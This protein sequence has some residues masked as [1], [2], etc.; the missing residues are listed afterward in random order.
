MRLHVM[1][2]ILLYSLNLFS[3]DDSFTQQPPRIKQFRNYKRHSSFKPY[4]RYTPEALM[5]KAC[6]ESDNDSNGTGSQATTPATSPQ[7]QLLPVD[8][9][10]GSDLLAQSDLL[11]RRKS[12]DS[13]STPNPLSLL[14]TGSMDELTGGSPL[15]TPK[16]S[17]PFHQSLTEHGTTPPTD[18]G[19]T[20]LGFKRCLTRNQIFALLTRM[21]A[22][23]PTTP[24]K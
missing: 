11:A 10:S 17:N 4:E 18:H 7:P 1:A 2:G 14:P 12:F 16:G 20:P 6:E 9:S 3:N 13:I 8:V 21:K 22:S 5:P 15:K 23:H 24:V 19:T